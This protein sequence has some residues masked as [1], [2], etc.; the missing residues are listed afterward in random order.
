MS[1]LAIR[2]ALELALRAMTEIIPP[3]S[4][5]S[6]T[7]SVFLTSAP[8][9]LTSEIDVKIAG[10]S[11]LNRSALVVVNSSTTFSLKDSLTNSAIVLANGT[12]GTVTAQLTAWENVSFKALNSVP[13][14]KVN[15]VF[16]RPENPTKGDAFYREIG[17]LQVTLY[18]PQQE[19]PFAALSRA[20]LIRS[21]FPRGSSFSNNGIIVNIDRTAEIMPGMPTDE[22]YVMIVR[23]PFYANIFP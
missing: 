4:I 23:V 19:G 14:Q 12:G 20:E 22:S 5:L 11:T 21:T 7:N 9:L 1:Q 3:I 2:A 8:H 17:F 18:Y 15:F 16:A 10:H 6:S 13:Y